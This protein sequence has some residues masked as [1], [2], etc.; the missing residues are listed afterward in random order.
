MSGELNADPQVLVPT[1][2]TALGLQGN[3]EGYL[4]SL[5]GVKDELQAAVQSPGGG[6]AIQ[7][8]MMD[9][10]EKGRSL[11]Q[12]LQAI[13]NTL[14]DTGHKVDATDM[15]NYQRLIRNLSN[16]DNATSYGSDGANSVAG[17]VT[18]GKVDV[19]W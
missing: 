1:A 7:T 4:K 12:S 2:K 10:W 6:Q 8:T 13:L 15:D 9:S 19:N 5:L 11:G 16:S 14:L 17:D 18:A 3:H